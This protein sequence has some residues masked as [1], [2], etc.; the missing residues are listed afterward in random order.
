[1]TDAPGY[2]VYASVGSTGG[3]IHNFSNLG[4]QIREA[5]CLGRTLV[6][7]PPNLEA[8]H[9]RGHLP[10]PGWSRYTDLENSLL[11]IQYRNGDSRDCRLSVVSRDDFGSLGIPDTECLRLPGVSPVSDG[12]NRDYR[13]ISK[14]LPANAMTHATIP[15]NHYYDRARIAGIGVGFKPS[16]LVESLAGPVLRALGEEYAAVHF[17]II[18]LEGVLSRRK[19]PGFGAVCGWLTGCFIKDLKRLIPRGM[20]LYFMTNHHAGNYHEHLAKHFTVFTHRRFPELRRLLSPSEG[21]PDNYLLAQTEYRIFASAD[22]RIGTKEYGAPT[23]ITRYL[24]MAGEKPDSGP[25]FNLV[26]ASGNF[27]VRVLKRDG[28]L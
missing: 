21:P 7:P 18:R 2:L 22:I 8:R 5:A 16:A 23:P 15:L 24:I 13:V 19:F 4:T 14:T 26:E 6:V 25:P 28:H 3:L 9:N 11:R 12:Q 20:P 17:R 27:L 10:P 1:M